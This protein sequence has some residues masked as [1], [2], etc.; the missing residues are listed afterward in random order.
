MKEKLKAAR[1][2]GIF[3][4][5]NLICAGAVFA[6]YYSVLTFIW[7]EWLDVAYRDMLTI[8]FLFAGIPLALFLRFGGL[9]FAFEWL[10]K[11]G[12]EAAKIKTDIIK[13]D[14][15]SKWLLFFAAYAI[16][17]TILLF[18]N[19]DKSFIFIYFLLYSL[20][21]PYV[22]TFVLW[23]IEEIIKQRKNAGKHM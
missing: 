15:K 10:Q 2:T 1:D 8:L 14:S 13:N 7:W 3:A 9:Y 21:F 18:I 4:I 17:S 16:D 19:E 20:W 11:Y 22:A 23:K 12:C 6:I 5:V